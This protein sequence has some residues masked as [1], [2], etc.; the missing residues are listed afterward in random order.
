[1]LRTD[2]YY[3]GD[4]F[5]I[6]DQELRRRKYEWLRDNLFAGREIEDTRPNRMISRIGGR[7]NLQTLDQNGF[8]A[9]EQATRNYL[10]GSPDPNHGLIEP[11][12]YVNT[13]SR[14]ALAYSCRKKSEIL[15]E[16]LQDSSLAQNSNYH[17]YLKLRLAELYAI[18]E[19]T[20]LAET[21]FEE[22]IA[23]ARGQNDLQLEIETML[24]LGTELAKQGHTKAAGAITDD[25]ST[26]Y[27][28][29]VWS[30][31]AEALVK[32]FIQ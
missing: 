9:L 29:T 27:P 20:G 10:L 17:F 24:K 13:K 19:E 21:Y 1:N 16:A 14:E 11:F 30:K 18:T 12:S 31:N 15:E 7:M 28:D 2:A 23:W 25:I 5:P 4:H 8:Q 22:V 3:T 26:R 6:E 32:Q